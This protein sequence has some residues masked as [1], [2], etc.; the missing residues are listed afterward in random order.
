M[1]Q[2]I[3][4]L[5]TRMGVIENAKL[6]PLDPDAINTFVHLRYQADV[7]DR[8]AG[9][10][11]DP[12]LAYHDYISSR[13]ATTEICAPL[14][15]ALSSR[16]SAYAFDALV[17][18]FNRDRERICLDR[19]SEALRS[20]YS[21]FLALFQVSREEEEL[22]SFDAMEKN[23]LHPDAKDIF[24]SIHLI[25]SQKVISKIEALPKLPS[26]ETYVRD[27]YSETSAAIILTLSGTSNVQR[28][29]DVIAQFN[30]ERHAIVDEHNLHLL[31]VLY[32]RMERC[33]QKRS[34]KEGERKIVLAS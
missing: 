26:Y 22:E 8:G 7:W 31:K 1:T 14:T 4:E 3:S 19:D 30:R 25:L 27:N 18:E 11:L 5:H 6:H 21:R 17:S 32:E 13:G 28:L 2:C 33:F 12:I 10:S 24:L 20:I 34:L 15:L 29:N 9:G 23:I 16:V